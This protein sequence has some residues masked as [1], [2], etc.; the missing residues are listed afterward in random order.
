MH[1]IFGRRQRMIRTET[2][3]WI[4]NW[5]T[6]HPE[7]YCYADGMLAASYP[8]GEMIINL[9]QSTP[10]YM[11][12]DV[13]FRV[14]LHRTKTDIAAWRERWFGEQRKYRSRTS[15]L[16]VLTAWHTLALAFLHPISAAIIGFYAV[17]S[18]WEV[19]DFCY[20]NVPKSRIPEH[21]ADATSKAM[22]L[23]RYI[24]TDLAPGEI[25]VFAPD[26]ITVRAAR[27]AV[28]LTRVRTR[29]LTPTS[30]TNFICSL[31]HNWIPASWRRYTTS[32]ETSC[33]SVADTAV[34]KTRP[35][36]L[37]NSSQVLSKSH[38]SVP[39]ARR[40]E[41]RRPRKDRKSRSLQPSPAKH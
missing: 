4:E 18:D 12:D 37:Q 28:F 32:F 24:V 8:T 41:C 1:S 29:L 31:F 39:L 23:L 36:T 7:V 2:Q 10:S 9:R 35:I 38:P 6:D 30:I 3:H 26:V 40:Q 11:E 14:M 25:M 5:I 16:L 19:A 20:R 15:H 34:A 17:A 21:L 33:A 27:S 22:K 13:G